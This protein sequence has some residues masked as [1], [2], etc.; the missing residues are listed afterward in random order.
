MVKNPNI[1]SN[2]LYSVFEMKIQE[3]KADEKFGTANVYQ[4]TLNKL[5]VY[6]KM[7]MKF[8]EV[9]SAFFIARIINLI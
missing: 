9:D 3:L 5:K 1:G 6:H 7:D 4:G 2:T 8:N